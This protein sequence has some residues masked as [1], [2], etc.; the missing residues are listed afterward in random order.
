MEKAKIPPFATQTFGMTG[1]IGGFSVSPA[2]SVL[3]T[4]NVVMKT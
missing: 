4:K 2:Y 3:K 1:Y